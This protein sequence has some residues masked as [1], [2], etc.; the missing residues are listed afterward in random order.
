[1][2]DR[3]VDFY[4]AS[5]SPRRHDL[6]LQLGYRFAVLPVDIDELAHAGEDAEVFVRRIATRNRRLLMTGLAALR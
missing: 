1:M 6:L 5:A 3:N 4:L 2:N